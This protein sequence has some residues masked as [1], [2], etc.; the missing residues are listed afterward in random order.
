[1]LPLLEGTGCTRH[2][3]NI[4]S[5]REEDMEEAAAALTAQE[6]QLAWLILQYGQ[7]VRTR[8]ARAPFAECPRP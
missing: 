6:K 3:S 5:A 4:H 7:L 2:G 8:A 1:V